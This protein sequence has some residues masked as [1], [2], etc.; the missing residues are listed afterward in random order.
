MFQESRYKTELCRQFEELGVCEYGDRCLYAHGTFELKQMP[1][2][3]PKF[4]T[5]RCSAY[6]DL[7]YCMF[8][9]R[10]SF[11]HQ[12]ED[13][14][15]LLREIHEK[16]EKEPWPNFNSVDERAISDEANLETL[17]AE[18]ES[19]LQVFKKLCGGHVE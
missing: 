15:A 11:L 17:Y 9:P 6:H 4:R 1:N 13:W 12:K 3:H 18:E 19:R 16:V 2:R 7:G 10:C 14:V 5:E 8:G